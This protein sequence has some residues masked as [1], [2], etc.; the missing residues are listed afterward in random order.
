MKEEKA[1]GAGSASSTSENSHKTVH[2][3]Q[4][5]VAEMKAEMVELNRALNV[6]RQL[7]QTQETQ[8]Q[9]KLMRDDLRQL[10]N[11]VAESSARQQSTQQ[12][13]QMVQTFLSFP[14]G[15][16]WFVIRY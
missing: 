9:W 3:M 13:L 11:S 5:S 1:L 8:N 16:Q 4:S 14:I 7:Q 2:W 6:S 10:Q 15:S 12:S